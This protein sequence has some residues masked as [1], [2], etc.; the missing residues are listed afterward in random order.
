MLARHHPP[1]RNGRMKYLKGSVVAQHGRIVSRWS[2]GRQ[3]DGGGGA[4][5]RDDG[6]CALRPKRPVTRDRKVQAEAA[7]QD[8]ARCAAYTVTL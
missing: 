4:R 1:G 2:G 7:E 5:R 8:I 3:C 6:R